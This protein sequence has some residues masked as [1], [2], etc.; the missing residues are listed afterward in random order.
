[1]AVDTLRQTKTLMK[2]F[3]LLVLHL[4]SAG[5]LK[6][7]E[8][9][10]NDGIYYEKPIFRDTT[11]HKYSLDN[12]SYKLHSVFVYDYFYIDSKGN[13]SK[14]L[15]SKNESS[16]DNPLNLVAYNSKTGDFIDR[17]KIEVDDYQKLVALDSTYTQTVYSYSYLKSDGKRS[18]TTCEAIHK[19]YSKIEMSCGDEWTGVVDN[20]KN[21]WMHPPRLYTFKILQLNPF[22]FYFRDETVK[23]WNWHLNTGGF[24]LDPRWIDQKEK[25]TILFSYK[26][27][28]DETIETPMGKLRCKVTEG[29]GTSDLKVGIVK[30]KLISYYYPAYGFVR[31]NYTNVN[32]T[33]L[34]MQLVDTK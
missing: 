11:K 17:I 4:L 27:L 22:P 5:L 16:S 34:V 14:F 26:R 12:I 13:R 6:A 23:T 21:L 3:N 20:G 2:Y 33:E 1:M 15:L 32:G 30:T 18:D 25:I 24:Y 28:P 9:I 31:L 8:L 29:I 7:Q 10:L 19:K